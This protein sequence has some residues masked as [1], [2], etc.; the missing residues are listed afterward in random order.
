ML[1]SFNKAKAYFD[2]KNEIYKTGLV[3]KFV[4]FVKVARIETKCVFL[5]LKCLIGYVSFIKRITNHQIKYMQ[6]IISLISKLISSSLLLMIRT[7][8][9][10]CQY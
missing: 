6:V 5:L 8:L 4:I 7:T 10:L 9:N 2:V 1:Q 3:L